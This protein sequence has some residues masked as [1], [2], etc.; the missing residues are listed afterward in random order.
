MVLKVGH[1]SGI[2]MLGFVSF[3]TVLGQV[4]LRSCN[5]IITD[6]LSLIIKRVSG[7]LCGWNLI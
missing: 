6:G 4:A 1:N 3:I 2:F 7:G 5:V